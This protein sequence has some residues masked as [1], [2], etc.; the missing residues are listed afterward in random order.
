MQLQSRCWPRLLLSESLRK[1]G[2]STSK[3]A[4]SHG[5]WQETLIS[6]HVAYF[7]DLLECPHDMAPDLPR[8]SDLK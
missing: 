7:I 2:G 3:M 1:I 8:V 5:Y 4:H 6:Y